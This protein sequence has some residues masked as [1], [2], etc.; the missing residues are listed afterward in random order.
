MTNNIRLSTLSLLGL[1]A[2]F[3]LTPRTSIA[4]QIFMQVTGMQG[5]A[6]AR[7]YKDWIEVAAYEGQVSS[8]IL[9]GPSGPRAGAASISDIKVTKKLDKSS[10]LL[11]LACCQGTVIA[12]IRLVFTTSI[13]D[14]GAQPYYEIK[15]TN[16]LIQ[17]VNL[18][19]SAGGDK[20]VETIQIYAD[21]GTAEW[22]YHQLDPNGSNIGTVIRG[23]D[24]GDTAL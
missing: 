18:S 3:A 15:F 12:E 11:A 21:G 8:A 17:S 4:Q 19:G 10:P 2:L 22:T 6:T 23:W 5:E 7:D 20:A 24:F 9:T 1:L 14:E 16:V 13:A